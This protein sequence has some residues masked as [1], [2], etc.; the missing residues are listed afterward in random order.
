[1]PHLI[2]Q[3][4]VENAIQHAVAPRA[5][6]SH[7]DISA[8][9]QDHFLRLEVRDNGPGI[10]ANDDV[11]D[12]QHVGLNN[13]RARLSQIYGRDFRFELANGRE[14]GLSVVMEIPFRH[15]AS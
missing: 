4:L 6:N 9:R 12:R 10:P 3:P 7:I 2:L 8:R 13:V 11:Q 14:G 1:M 15:Q 5:S